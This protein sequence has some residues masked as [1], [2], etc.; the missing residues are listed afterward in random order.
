MASKSNRHNIFDTPS[1]YSCQ[2]WLNTNPSLR[3]EENLKNLIERKKIIILDEKS[4]QNFGSE[5]TNQN[6]KIDDCSNNNWTNDW[7]NANSIDNF[8]SANNSQTFLG[9]IENKRN[10]GSQRNEVFREKF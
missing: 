1:T 6:N 4:S 8:N 2:S 7:S 9:K 5:K 3:G 10:V